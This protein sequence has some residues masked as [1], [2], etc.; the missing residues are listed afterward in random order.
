MI[1]AVVDT[2]ILVSASFWKGNPY[3]IIRL[4]GRKE[5]EAFASAKILEEYARALRRDFKMQ[6]NEIGERTGNLLKMIKLVEPK[7]KITEIKEDPEDN[8]VLEAAV[9]AGANYIVSGDG[10]LLKLK[11]FRGIKIIKARQFLELPEIGGRITKD[12]YLQGLKNLRKVW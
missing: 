1:K 5:I 6:E 8:R 10:H 4:A 2:N 11:E 7:A 12:D 9:E 3:R